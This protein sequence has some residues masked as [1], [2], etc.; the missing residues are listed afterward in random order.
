MCL[1]GIGFGISQSVT[2]TLVMIIAQL[3]SYGTARALW[4]WMAH[5]RP[6]VLSAVMPQVVGLAR[7]AARCQHPC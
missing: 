5:R 3:S 4:N 1:C 7:L 2:F 6:R